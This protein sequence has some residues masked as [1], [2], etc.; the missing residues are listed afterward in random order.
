M[1]DACIEFEGK[2]WHKRKGK[3]DYYFTLVSLHRAVW[4]AAYGTI[5]KGYHIHHINDDKHD[6]R[7]ENLELLSHSEHSKHHAEAHLGPYRKK[8]VQTSQAA[9]ARNRA[10]RMEI[11]RTCAQC[12]REY[13][14]SAA[15]PLR[16]C[17]SA[18]VEQARSGA[19]A[20]EVRQCDQCGTEY[21]AS[22]RVQRY[23]S[24]VCNDRALRARNSTLLVRDLDCAQCG[25]AF[26]SK[27]SNARF[28]TRACALAYHSRNKYRRKISD[29]V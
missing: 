10:T 24:R 1:C 13:Y 21:T 2:T 23:C 20:G 29:A 25:A 17:S 14:S 26:T 15:H 3:G 28:C 5:P 9:M 7:I 22:Q 12:G 27:R 19:F 6:N 16:Y 4:E 8:A 18:C 11:A